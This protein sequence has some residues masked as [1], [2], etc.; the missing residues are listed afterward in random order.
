MTRN[1]AD[2]LFDAVRTKESPLCVGIDPTLDRIPATIRR[3]AFEVHDDPLAAG[4]DAIG[5]FCRRVVEI[6]A[7]HAACVKLQMAFFERFGD[8]GIRAAREVVDLA[9]SRDL[10]VIGDLKRGDIGSTVAAFASAY[11]GETDAEADRHPAVAFD[12]I[13]VNAY[14][15]SDAI[16]PYLPLCRDRGKG[17]FV[18]VRTSNPSSREIQDLVCDGL[19]LFHHVARLVDEWGRDC[20]GDCGMSS[21]GAVVGATF[22]RELGEA[23]A[24]MPAAP[25]LVPGVGAQGARAE[26]VAPAFR[27]DGLGAVVNSSRGILYAF[28]KRGSGGAWED[29]VAEAAAGLRRALRAA[30]R[31]SRGNL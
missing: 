8:A 18:L 1:F 2:R 30:S 9:R 26:D 6:V 10:V 12:A 31:D 17:I 22:P 7:E 28:E 24:R 20:V 23:R 3:R 16:T 4:A 11:L 14:M 19:P 15:G 5:V 25:F 13:T 29:A 27:E 21:V